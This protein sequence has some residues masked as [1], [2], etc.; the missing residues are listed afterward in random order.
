MGR[1]AHPIGPN[2]IHL[3]IDMQHLF[4]AEGLWP[5]PWL[6]RVL[7]VVASLVEICPTRTVFTR[8]LPAKDPSSAPGRWAA[9]YRKWQGVTLEHLD[10]RYLELV[11][12]LTNY[13]PPASL[14]D[15]PTY[16]AF[17][18]GALHGLLRAKNIDT[19][20]VSGA[21]TDVC[22]LSTVLSAVDLGYRTILVEDALASSSDRSH[23]AV[24]DV[25]RS[26]F[27]IQI[28]VAQ[29]EAI[30]EYWAAA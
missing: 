7:P 21:E 15:R 16:S 28:E 30:K 9:Y 23:D 12:P 10:P 4:A 8:F 29:A 26:R 24:L 17:A 14:F 3:C 6:D 18:N 5:A 20:V 27:D 19:L 25:Y 11:H 2:A 22:V 13:T 1:L